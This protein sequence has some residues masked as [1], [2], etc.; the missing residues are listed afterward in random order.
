[1]VFTKVEIWRGVKFTEEEMRQNY[2]IFFDEDNEISIYDMIS[3]LNEHIGSDTMARFKRIIPC[4][5]EDNSVIYGYKVKEYKRSKFNLTK[6]KVK[7]EDFKNPENWEKYIER[8]TKEQTGYCCGKIIE[9]D[10]KEKKEK[11][12]KERN[13]LTDRC[14]YYWCCTSCLNTTVNGTYDIDRIFKKPTLCKSYCFECDNDRC[15]KH[16]EDDKESSKTDLIEPIYKINNFMDYQL[17]NDE[18]L[19]I[20]KENIKNYYLLDDCLSCS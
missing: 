18:N 1:M 4:C 15:S 5:G 6:L 7:K 19:Y 2:Q 13:D 3:E 16:D 12:E 17:I 10:K 20:D 11:E 9:S 14:G 8:V